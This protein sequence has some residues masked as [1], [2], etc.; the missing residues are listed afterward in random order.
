MKKVV[1]TNPERCH[2]CAD[3]QPL[4]EPLVRGRAYTVERELRF[5]DW[6]GY[7]LKEIPLPPLWWSCAPHFQELKPA[8]ED[9][10]LLADRPIKIKEDA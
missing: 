8:G 3:D 2:Q 10:F 9:I 4:A 5:G 6:H 1:C 7:Q